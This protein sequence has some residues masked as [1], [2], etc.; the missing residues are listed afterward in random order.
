MMLRPLLIMDI[1]TGLNLGQQMMVVAVLSIGVFY[2]FRAKKAGG[3]LVGLM[4]T[5]WLIT[6]SVAAVFVLVLVFNWADPNVGKA[7]GDVTTAFQ[8]IY[9]FTTNHIIDFV[10]GLIGR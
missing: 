10:N 1:L 6:V 8:T 4:S 2:L 7:V 9:Q 5:A 3:L